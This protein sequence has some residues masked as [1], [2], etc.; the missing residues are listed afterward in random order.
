MA[1]YLNLFSLPDHHI[2]YLQKNSAALFE[3]MEGE[4]VYQKGE[5]KFK[6]I[7]SR[8]FKSEPVITDFPTEPIDTF[9]P[10]INHRNI[11]L[12]HFILNGTTEYVSGA[13]SIFQTWL[14]IDD[15]SAIKI[16]KSNDHFAFK[17]ETVPSLLK[18]VESL[19]DST[20]KCRYCEWFSKNFPQHPPTEIELTDLCDGFVTFKDGL[21]DAVNKQLGILWA[22]R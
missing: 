9:N 17:N 12:Y 18:I 7:Y 8:V 4:V 13:G 19:T 15:H 3:Y 1:S 2:D 11:E 14:I 6:S 5:S 10:E 16:D 22:M 20:I 21:A